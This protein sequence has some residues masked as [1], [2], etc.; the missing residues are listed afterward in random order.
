LLQR[1][2]E[3]EAAL[4]G[5]ALHLPPAS[6]RYLQVMPDDMMALV[7]GGAERYLWLSQTEVERRYAGNPRR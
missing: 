3:T 2:G 7:A 6:V 4:A 5:A 1:L